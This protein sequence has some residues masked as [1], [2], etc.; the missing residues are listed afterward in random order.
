MGRSSCFCPRCHLSQWEVLFFLSRW[1]SNYIDGNPDSSTEE[2]K[3]QL[4]L[5]DA[6]IEVIPDP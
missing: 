4:P 2:T 3:A 5:K 1:I 6:K